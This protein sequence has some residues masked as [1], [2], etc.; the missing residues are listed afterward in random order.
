MNLANLHSI[1]IEN[2]CSVHK[3][4]YENNTEDL[5]VLLMPPCTG[6][7]WNMKENISL[8][9]QSYAIWSYR[10]MGEKQYYFLEERKNP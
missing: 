8:L 9:K 2:E 5:N 7:L 3:T 1:N 6:S 4:W 10:D